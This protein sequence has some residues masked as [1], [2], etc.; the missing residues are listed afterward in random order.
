MCMVPVVENFRPLKRA[1]TKTIDIFKSWRH[2]LPCYCLVCLCLDPLGHY[3]LT[4]LLVLGISSWIGPRFNFLL[5]PCFVGYMTTW[6][7]DGQLPHFTL[8]LKTM[9]FLPNIRD[10]ANCQT[11]WKQ[12]TEISCSSSRESRIHPPYLSWYN[13][14]PGVIWALFLGLNFMDVGTL[15]IPVIDTNWD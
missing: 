15:L 13:L 9:F 11:L 4:K 10:H 8:L 3:D 14:E 2:M 6:P 5:F 7:I 12:I 1:W